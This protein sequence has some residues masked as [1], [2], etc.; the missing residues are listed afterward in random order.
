[1]AG[2]SAKKI[3]KEA[4]KY[5]SIYFYIILASLSINFVFNGFYN[6]KNIYSKSGL[7]FLIIGLIYFFTYSSI[8]SRL[9]MGIG[10]SVYQDIYILNTFVSI[11]SLISKYSWYIFFL[12]P[13]YVIYKIIK[14]VINWVFMPE[15]V[16]C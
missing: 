11:L 14:L 7:G 3:A 13:I 2:Q 6:P 8:K 16:S 9:S 15:P 4:A 12:I 10:Y 1:M 5:T